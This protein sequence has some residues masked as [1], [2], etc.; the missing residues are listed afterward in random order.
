ME[1][2]A[3]CRPSG[4]Q[5]GSPVTGPPMFVNRIGFRPSRSDTQISPV[6]ERLEPN[7][8]RSP[9]GEYCG[10]ESVAVE[11]INR[12]GAGCCPAVPGT[13]MRQIFLSDDVWIQASWFPK[14]EIAGLETS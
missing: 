5:R 8:I 10:L 6:P 3:I 12:V 2:K 1:S 9:S 11:A 7:T 13:S 14:R 4:D